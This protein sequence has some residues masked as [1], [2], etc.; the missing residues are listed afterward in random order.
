MFIQK[1]IDNYY[2]Y[3][4]NGNI[5][6]LFCIMHDNETGDLITKNRTRTKFYL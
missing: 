6:Y 2:W 3:Q 5:I 1:I 4:I